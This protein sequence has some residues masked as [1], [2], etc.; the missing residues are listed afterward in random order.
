MRPRVLLA[1]PATSYRADAYVA[2]AREVEVEL[3][4][5]TD[6]PA[7]ARRF[8][9]ELHEVDLL[10]A[11]QAAASLSAALSAPLA[12]V[13]A[14]DESSAMLAAAVG[15]SPCC[16]RAYHS[17]AGVR[18]ARD[19]RLMRAR[20]AEAGVRVPAYRLLPVGAPPE[21]LTGVRYPS[22]VKPSMLSGSQG[23]IRVDSAGELS[24]AV[25]RTRRI[26]ERHPSDLRALPG[27]FELLVEDYVEGEE[28][29]VEG[30]MAGGGLQLF[31][32]FDKPD[33]LTGP[34]FEETIYLTPSRWPLPLQSRIAHI[35]E[36]AARALGLTDGPVHVELRLAHGGQRADDSAGTSPASLR[37]G[38]YLAAEQREPVIIEAA[39]RS[40]GGLC[41]RVL[42]PRVGSLERRLL[43]AAAG[44]PSEPMA[45][46]PPACGVMM[47]PVPADGVLRAVEGL[48][49]ARAVEHIDA[50]AVSIA[51]GEP[52]R[53]LPEGRSYL[54]FI[55]ATAPSPS[56]AE[57]ALR[58]AHSCLRFELKASLPL[59]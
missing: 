19:K 26:L 18:A 20:L 49:G 2:A 34:F 54:G 30:L 28:V 15:A 50:V 53:R 7:A 25:V 8:G 44:L 36:Q 40:I 6:L 42:A 22:V 56:Q 10:R 59:S 51:T 38:R 52:V 14:A 35:A 23:V 58:A 16:R 9:L 41:S 4:L 1:F 27:F 39:A 45:A 13:L 12:G 5:A 11:E 31:A 17:L 32:L 55:F 48:D 29:A 43:R 47:I 57:Q 3:V 21:V 46:E 24:A 37:P 33:P